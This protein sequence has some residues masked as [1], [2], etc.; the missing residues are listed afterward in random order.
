MRLES[1]EEWRVRRF[2]GPLVRHVGL[3]GGGEKGGRSRE[4][5]EREELVGDVVLV[6]SS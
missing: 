4:G 5:V 6:P 3:I 1:L 2:G